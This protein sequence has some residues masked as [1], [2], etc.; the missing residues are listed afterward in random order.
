MTFDWPRVK[1]RA[2]DKR[3]YRKRW[4]QQ[5][6]SWLVKGFEGA[7]IAKAIPELVLIADDIAGCSVVNSCF[8][9]NRERGKLSI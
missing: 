8:D 3:A 6:S 9:H 4:V 2:Q 1:F 7:Q 5:T